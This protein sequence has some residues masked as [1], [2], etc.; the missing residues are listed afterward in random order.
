MELQQ[1]YL[2]WPS[3]LATAGRRKSRLLVRFTKPLPA[4]VGTGVGKVKAHFSRVRFALKP[5]G[6]MP[7]MDLPTATSTP[8]PSTRPHSAGRLPAPTATTHQS[9]F[10][11]LLFLFFC[12][13]LFFVNKNT[14]FKPL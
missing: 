9:V 3:D 8:P 1:P 2:C 13:V 6:S 10:Y 11:E 4:H 7:A 14:V 5:L 12:F